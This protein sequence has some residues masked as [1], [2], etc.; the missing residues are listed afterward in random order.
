MNRRERIEFWLTE[1]KKEIEN[2]SALNA[3]ANVVQLCRAVADAEH[4][5]TIND[6]V[7]VYS[8]LNI[9]L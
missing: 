9:R 5:T 2:G 6:A 8:D 4:C 7:Q 3:R 1:V